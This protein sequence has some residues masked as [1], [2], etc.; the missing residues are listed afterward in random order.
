[1]KRERGEQKTKKRAGEKGGGKR[2]KEE[3]EI[4]WINKTSDFKTGEDLRYL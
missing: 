4:G 2:E 3:E 1:M